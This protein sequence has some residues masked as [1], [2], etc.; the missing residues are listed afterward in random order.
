MPISRAAS[1][2]WAVA[3]IAFPCRV[4]EMNHV[5]SS[6]SG[7]VAA[8]ASTS[9]RRTTAPEIWNT[10]SFWW[11]RSETP[12][13]EPPIH[14]SPTFCRMNENPTAVIRGASLGALR[15]GRYPTRSISTFSE[16]QTSIDTTS[17]SNSPSTSPR[18]PV[19]RPSPIE[20]Q[21]PAAVIEPIMNTSP[22]A[23]LISSMIP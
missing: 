15:S 21:N 11:I 14:S 20:A 23:K 16:P 10:T 12:T 5:S 3:R 7:I 18:G 22:C 6:T 2:S 4:R 8:I 17:V 9:E 13:G 19:A 1:G